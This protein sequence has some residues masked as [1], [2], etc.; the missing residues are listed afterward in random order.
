MFRADA[1]D[2]PR[3]VNCNGSRLLDPTPIEVDT[4]T[5][6][7]DEGNATHWLAQ[8]LFEGASADNVIGQ[9]APN[10]LFITAAMLDHVKDYLAA[11][12]SGQMEVRT[13]FGEIDKWQVDARADHIFYDSTVNT[14]YIDDFK[15]GYGLVEPE[16]N[17]TLIAHAIGYCLNNNI[18]P[19]YIIFTIHQPRPYHPLGN[20][21]SWKI[22]YLELR[23]FYQT[24][25][26]TMS[27]PNDM[28]NTGYYCH[29]CFAR[30]TCPAYRAA[31]M[32]AVDV[33]GHAFNDNIPD[34]VLSS[35]LDLLETASKVIKNRLD[36]LKE[37]A[38]YR[39]ATKGAKIPNYMVDRTKGNTRWKK[40]VDVDL[41]KFMTGRDL[42]KVSLPA[43]SE[44]RDAGIAQLVIDSMIERPD[45]AQKL[46]RV[47]QD[48]MARKLLRK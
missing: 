1:T 43:V 6:A 48:A 44:A 37:L 27:N 5:T 25:A 36:A 8:Y 13:S 21:R 20:H 47:D 38:Q 7:R 22:T 14:L 34:D 17:W 28:L 42:G 39:I 41:I 23:E 2:L 33:T 30:Y 19:E 18:Q 16:N 31:S 32:N 35:E 11:I 12:G 9:K 26:R 24:I 46:V 3:L 45:G 29:K 10:G 40:Y 4:D 15:Y